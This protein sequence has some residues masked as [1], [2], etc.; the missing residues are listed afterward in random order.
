MSEHRPAAAGWG[1][2]AC[3][4]QSACTLAGNRLHTLCHTPQPP[5]PVSTPAARRRPKLGTACTG[6][7]SHHKPQ[8]KRTC[9][10]PPPSPRGRYFVLAGSRSVPSDWL[11]CLM[12]HPICEQA[13]GD[14]EA[15]VAG[16]P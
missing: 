14:G 16:K 12:L 11:T 5:T 10:P 15:Q 13:G 6:S 3:L 8:Q 2:L 7:A 4:S 1:W 9:G